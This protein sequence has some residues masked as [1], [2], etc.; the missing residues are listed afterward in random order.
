MRKKIR[1]HRKEVS[2]GTDY[3]TLYERK[4]TDVW[5]SV[6]G[7]KGNPFTKLK[8]WW[9]RENIALYTV[10]WITTITVVR[11]RYGN[12]D[13]NWQAEL[14]TGLTLCVSAFN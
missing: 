7:L 11:R 12:P 8:M 3:L 6:K 13:L 5:K 10:I 14:L 4:S 9:E 2:A 1:F